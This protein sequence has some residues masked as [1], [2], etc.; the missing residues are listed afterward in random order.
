MTERVPARP[1]PGPLENF[2]QAF[3]DLFGKRSQRE[4]FRRYLEGLLLP[5]E[6]HKTLTGLANA[7]PVVAAQHP[8]AQQWQWFLSE[9]N[10]DP[11]VVQQ[12]RLALL[13]ETS[14]TAPTGDGAL[15][16]DETGDRK[17]GRKTAP[18]GRQYLSNVGKV[19]N[20]VVSVQTVWTDERLYY[21]LT[22]EPYTP[23]AWFEKDQHDAHF[24]SKPQIALELVEAAVAG[25]VSFRAVVA[26]SFYGE[27]DGLRQGLMERGVGYVMA[28]KPSHSWWHTQGSLGAVWQVAQAAAWTAQ[29]PGDWQAVTRRFRDAHE[30]SGWALEAVGGPYGPDQAERAL[31]VTTDPARLPDDTTWYLVTNLP[32]PD[33]ARA[34]RRPLPA[35]DLTEIGRLY[36]LRVWVEQSD[37]QVK[38][39]LGW[40]QYQVRSDPAIR[41]HWELVCCAFCFCWW[42]L[43]QDDPMLALNPTQPRKTPH[44]RW[45]VKGKKAGQATPADRHPLT[46]PRALRRVRAW[47]EPWVMLRRYWQAWSVKPPPPQLQALLDWLWQGQ[48]IDLYAR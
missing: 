39:H 30:E 2:A 27:N 44:P 32:A 9:S 41:R 19:D 11:R 48:G 21:P 45:R 37:Q 29:V 17:W 13:M 28:L 10:W 1:A 36:G 3:D 46:W 7:E 20:G 35:A 38:Q 33:T 22:V 42:A 8:S 5:T 14:H 18:V 15:V 26:D 47:L 23:A 31:V 40:A 6:R 24:R 34:L 4:A 12:R 16:I 43:V 25:G